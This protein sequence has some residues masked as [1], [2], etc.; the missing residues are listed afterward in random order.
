MGNF[1]AMSVIKE[2]K[3]ML[4]LSKAEKDELIF[5]QNPQY[6]KSYQ[7]IK[8]SL[9]MIALPYEQYYLL[10]SRCVILV[11]IYCKLALINK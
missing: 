3:K 9:T 5:Q 10:L 6:K 11:C 7:K 2:V 4:Q 8:W 1:K